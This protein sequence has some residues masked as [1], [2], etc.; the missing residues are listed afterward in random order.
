M[1]LLKTVGKLVATGIQ[2]WRIN[3]LRFWRNAEYVYENKPRN[4]AIRG[5]N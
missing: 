1:S 3:W 4:H 2:G 5:I